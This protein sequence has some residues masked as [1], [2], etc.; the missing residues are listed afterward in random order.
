MYSS[1][2][3]V[4]YFIVQTHRVILKL[5]FTL[6]QTF[7]NKLEC[8]YSPNFQSSLMFAGKARSLPM[9]WGTQRGRCLSFS[10]SL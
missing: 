3:A 8:L 1:I 6:Q 2:A 5:G 4:K 7:Q 10:G 9:Q